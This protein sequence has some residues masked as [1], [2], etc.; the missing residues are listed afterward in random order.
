MTNM[1]TLDGNSMVM[2]HYCGGGN[3][4]RMRATEFDGRRLEFRSV[5]VS[6]L[7][8]AGDSYMGE[9]T[10]VFVDDNY[11]EQHWTSIENGE[12]S[13]MGVFQLTRVA[14]TPP[15]MR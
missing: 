14:K 7:K 3:Q 4:P 1:Y 5:S 2:T 10:L 13:E 15:K 12:T 8:N 11:V 9:M 6:D